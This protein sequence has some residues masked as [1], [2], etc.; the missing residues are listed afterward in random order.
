MHEYYES[1]TTELKLKITKNFEKEIIAF[2]NTNGGS[3]FIGVN[4]SGNLIGLSGDEIDKTLITI[5]ECIINKICPEC[6]HLVNS[7]VIEDC[8]IKLIKVDVLKGDQLFYIKKFGRSS[9]GCYKR[10]G[11]TVREMS[12]KEIDLKMISFLNLPKKS[13]INQKAKEIDYSFNKLK[14]YLINKNVHYND[15]NFLDNFNLLTE[16]KKVNLLGLL[17]ADENDVT[18]RVNIF[19]GKDK[20]TFYKRMEYGR[21][22]ILYGFDNISNYIESINETFVKIDSIVRREIKKFDFDVFREAWVNACVHDLWIEK[23]PPYVDVFSDRLEVVSYG[24]LPEGLSKD[25]FYSG[26]SLPI[27]KELMDI[28]MQCHI[29]ERSGHG[30]PTIIK[31]YGKDAIKIGENF[32]TV[33]I[34]FR[35]DPFNVK[36]EFDRV[37]D[38]NYEI[39]STQIDTANVVNDTANT[40]IETLNGGIDTANY[41]NDTANS[42][43]SSKNSFQKSHFKNSIKSEITYED[44]I[45]LI[46]T[47]S[48]ITTSKISSILGVSLST[49]KRKIKNCPNIHF[50]GNSTKTGH[51]EI[52]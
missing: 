29:V 8:G 19:L 28:F 24:G 16:D 17:L 6:S 23:E 42:N 37:N 2:L 39:K 36:S 12:E 4:D 10:I 49:I 26:K 34:P 15:Q 13:L 21:T 35:D 32:I 3:I 9:Q 7:S 25:D 27:N 52:D 18:L 11:S 20:A 5:S 30:I 47:D 45:K 50:V 44:I 22:C 43:L 48:R 40:T 31:A 41:K 51:W 38:N 14:N 1:D 33:V 46:E